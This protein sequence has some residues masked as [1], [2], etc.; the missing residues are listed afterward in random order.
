MYLERACLAPP[1]DD[2]ARAAIQTLRTQVDEARLA[3]RYRD[4]LRTL[5]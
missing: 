4:A 3:E 1:L 5:P 2:R